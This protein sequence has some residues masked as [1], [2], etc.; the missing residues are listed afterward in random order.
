MNKRRLKEYVLLIVN[1]GI[2]VQK[3]RK[4]LVTCPVEQHA[5][6]ALVVEELYK[7]GASHVHLDYSDATARS[8]YKYLNDKDL[9]YFPSYK[10]SMY[11]TFLKEQRGRI[12]LSSPRPSLVDGLDIEKITKASQTISKKM[13]FFSTPYGES[14][15]EWCIACVPNADW[16]K[17]VFPN[18][19]SSKAIEALW[20]AIL[21]T[22]SVKGDKT[23]V[24]TWNIH[25]SNLKTRADKLNALNLKSLHF[26]SSNGTDLTIGLVNDYIFE[27]GTSFTPE[28]VEFDAN[29]P[30][31]EIF[32]MPHKDKINGTVYSTK[33]LFVYGVVI[34]NF[35]FVFKNGH[36]TEIICENEEHKKVLQKLISV[37][38]G[39]S[40]LGEVALVPNSSPINKTGILFF[41]TLYDEN[42]SCHIAL[43]DCYKT[44]MKNSESY[45][46]EEMSKR[47]ANSSLIHIDFMIGDE[48]TEVIGLNQNDEEILILK[49]GEFVI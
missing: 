17:K 26:K 22:V 34:E 4:Y 14:K 46:D 31:E 40:S 49:D 23:S 45:S 20:D 2:N 24:D 32:T 12:V 25:N 5:F 44:N 36:I 15:L 11:K 33:P 39:A 13:N 18:L 43:G 27:G 41:N 9:S 3:G 37:D 1:K 35:G 38:S 28:G 10:K 7:C 21:N 30:T 48:T 47:G 42:A 8:A 19:S 6:A 29:M 16:A